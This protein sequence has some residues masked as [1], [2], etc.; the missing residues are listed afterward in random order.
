VRNLIIGIGIGL[1][2]VVGMASAQ[3]DPLDGDTTNLATVELGVATFYLDAQGT[4]VGCA[5]DITTAP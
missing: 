1:S 4:E 5:V 3:D 2:L